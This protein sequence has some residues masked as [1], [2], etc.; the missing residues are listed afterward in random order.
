MIATGQRPPVP[1]LMLVTDRSRTALPLPELVDAVVAG[2]VDAVQVRDKEATTDEL[3][4]LTQELAAVV[5][6]R[7]EVLVNGDVEV[8][9]ALRLGI[10]LPER[11]PSPAAAR[12]A[13]GPDILIGRSVHDVTSATA[14]DGAD[15]LQ[16]GNVFPT[17]SH[18]G[19]SG[20]Q[21]SGFRRIVA[22]SALPVLAIGGV[23]E[24]NVADPIDRGAHGI[25]VVGAL[26]SAS[27][28]EDAHRRATALRAAIDRA[29]A[30]PFGERSMDDERTT[31]DLIHVELNG[32]STA[33]AARTTVAGLLATRKLQERLVVVELNG[34]ILPRATYEATVIADGD[35]LEIVHF[36]GGG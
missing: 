3:L 8:A 30:Q 27:S 26:A 28:G 25:A 14:S 35:R 20:L 24:R 21:L 12:S 5:N 32:K 19:R 33:M 2:G 17:A 29:L 23:D 36:V 9:R 16:A 1:R 22:A 13:L 6:G 34:T 11:A 10:H 4:R 15:Y 7:C 18:P 31:N